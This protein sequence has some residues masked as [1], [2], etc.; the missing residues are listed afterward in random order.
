MNCPELHNRVIRQ[1]TWKMRAGGAVWDWLALCPNAQVIGCLSA[2]FC[3][4]Q[5][6]FVFPAALK[7][8]RDPVTFTPQSY[9]SSLSL[10]YSK[11]H[12]SNPFSFATQNAVHVHLMSST[13][14][15][16][17]YFLRDWFQSKAKCHELDR[18]MRKKDNNL[19][20]AKQEIINKL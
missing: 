15:L 4:F 11:I 2:P 18:R 20:D 8:R 13:Q 10:H 6:K 5:S 7:I 12:K 14:N 17:K 16:T 19:I 1:M 9:G 3:P